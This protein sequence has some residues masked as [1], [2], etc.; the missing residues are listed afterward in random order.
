[1]LVTCPLLYFHSDIDFMSTEAYS[2]SDLLCCV[3]W[4]ILGLAALGASNATSD[5]TMNTLDTPV[6]D[7]ASG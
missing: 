3:V 4:G 6:Q 1:M 7:S 5:R 2:Q